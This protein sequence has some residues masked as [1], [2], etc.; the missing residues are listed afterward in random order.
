MPRL[1]A[2]VLGLLLAASVCGYA[3]AEPAVDPFF[4]KIA[5]LLLGEKT[6]RF[7]YQS[8][9]PTTGRLFIA[10][11]GSAKLLVFDVVKQQLVA[12]L[13]GFPKVTGVLAVPDLHKV[14]ASVPGAG[15]GASLS[16]AL[17]LAGLSSG[18]GGV[19]ILDSV[20]LKELVRVPAA[21]FPT[22]SP[23]TRTSIRYS[24]PTRWVVR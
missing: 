22:A 6:G 23:M 13:D 24:S 7:D 3:G 5:D 20:S 1:R 12:E 18:S 16:V 11:M 9:D 15:I 4:T 10:K 8:F 14:Y 21:Y 2:L 17:G 19:A